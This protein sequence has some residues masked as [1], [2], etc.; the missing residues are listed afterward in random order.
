MSHIL[1]DNM[2]T[3]IVAANQRCFGKNTYPGSMAV[4]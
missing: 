3:M 1:G 4:E 2:T